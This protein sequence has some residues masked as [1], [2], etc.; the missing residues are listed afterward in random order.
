MKMKA[1]LTGCAFFMILIQV[2]YLWLLSTLQQL[3]VPNS[4]FSKTL[5]A[6]SVVPPF[7][8]ISPNKSVSASLSFALKIKWI[9]SALPSKLRFE[10]KR[11]WLPP[12]PQS[13][14]LK[15]KQQ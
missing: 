2:F 9:G 5:K 14:A 13:S 7:D 6:L 4:F 10:N 1:Q 8:A 15:I 3:F 12:F 11:D